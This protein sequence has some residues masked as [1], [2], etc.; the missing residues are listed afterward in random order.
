MRQNRLAI[1][2]AI[3]L[4][5]W[6]FISAILLVGYLTFAEWIWQGWYYVVWPLVAGTL[7]WR[8]RNPIKTTLTNWQ[9]P[10]I[11]KYVL[12]VYAIVLIE[13]VLAATLNHLSE[14]YAVS[15]H[16]KRI[17]QFWALNILAFSGM[18]WGGYLIFARYQFTRIHMFCLMGLYG[19]ISEQ[20][21]VRLF[22]PAE[23][24]AAFVLIPLTFWTYGIIFM[25]AILA[26][27]DKPRKPL[28][29]FHFP[30]AIGVIF[31][32]SIPFIMTLDIT[33]SAYPDLF[34]PRH[35]IR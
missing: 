13:E 5:G 29:L 24:V 30:L 34:P 26:I 8:F 11:L 28:K 31:L 35:M 9:I 17:A 16:L 25:P 10:P 20:L 15:L 2:A 14:G 1:V 27:E 19:Q 32:A 18:A 12:I 33:R 7:V 6:T 3:T 23:A 22:N 21:L 4:I